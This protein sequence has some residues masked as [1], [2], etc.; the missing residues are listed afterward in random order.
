[1]TSLKRDKVCPQCEHRKLWHVEKVLLPEI[2]SSTVRNV[3]GNRPAPL[4]VIAEATWSGVRTTGQ[5][6]AFICAGCGWTE[7]YATGLAELKENPAA[8]VHFVDAEPKA[9]LR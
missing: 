8:G 9:G 7:W 4:P 6:E 5:F 1:L 2:D 3:L